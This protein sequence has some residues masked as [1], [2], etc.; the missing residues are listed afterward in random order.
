MVVASR[1]KFNCAPHIKLYE[2][3]VSYFSLAF[4]N[5]MSTMLN[6]SVE[7]ASNEQTFSS[8]RIG[9]ENF[10]SIIGEFIANRSDKLISQK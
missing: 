6:D 10:I 1:L 5:S 7:I 3:C 4:Q 9:I 8:I 2:I